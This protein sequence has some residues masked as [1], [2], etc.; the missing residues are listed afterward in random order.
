LNNPPL[1]ARLRQ[2]LLLGS[3]APIDSARLATVEG[4]E[5]HG[6]QTL[7]GLQCLPNLQGLTLVDS[8][9]TDLSPIAGLA[10]LAELDIRH[11]VAPS[12]EALGDVARTLQNLEISDSGFTDL[13]SLAE[14]SSLVRLKLN[15]NGLETLQGLP[16]LAHLEWLYL[17]NNALSDLAPLLNEPALLFLTVNGN[18]LESL[19]SLNGHRTMWSV[20]AGKNGLRTLADLKQP[21]LHVLDV[22]SNQLGAVGSM[23]G[24]SLMRLTLDD[25]AIAD[26]SPLSNQQALEELTLDHNPLA[27]LNPLSALINLKKLSLQ[28]TAVTDLTPLATLPNVAMLLLRDTPITDLTPLQPWSGID[29]NCRQIDVIGLTLDQQSLTSVAPA[30]CQAHWAVAQVCSGK[31]IGAI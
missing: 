14:M 23:A 2:Q 31:C 4:L 5:V 27:T 24:L 16:A 28:S 7:A 9:T 20:E 15:G 17:D 22:H 3:E 30:L 10:R 18:Q 25:N 13:S 26:L 1:E 12:L 8:S 29:G 21:A 19:S 6:L 11:S